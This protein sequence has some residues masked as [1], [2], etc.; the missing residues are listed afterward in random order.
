[1]RTALDVARLARLRAGTEVVLAVAPEGSHGR[2]VRAPVGVAG[3]QPEGV[4]AGPA[5]TRFLGQVGLE[6]TAHV[7][8]LEWCE[9]VKVGEVRCR[10]IGSS[11]VSGDVAGRRFSSVVA[12][13]YPSKIRP[14]TAASPGRATRPRRPTAPAHTSISSAALF[15]TT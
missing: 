10:R 12:S 3:G 8:P 2:H 1:M 13:V 7:G 4:V 11:H 6:G 9:L 14:R 5:G 15:M